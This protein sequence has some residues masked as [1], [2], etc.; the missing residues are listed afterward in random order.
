MW[1]AVR[2][3]FVKI[4]CFP[5]NFWSGSPINPKFM[6]FIF[7]PEKQFWSWETSEIE[8]EGR[9]D[10]VVDWSWAR[11]PGASLETKTQLRRK[12][13]NL[14]L[15]RAA[16]VNLLLGNH[17]TCYATTWSEPH[18]IKLCNKHNHCAQDDDQQRPGGTH[19]SGH[20]Y[21]WPGGAGDAV[22]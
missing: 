14:W 10:K 15:R 18:H 11:R 20:E 12:S 7:V 22:L 8:E 3:G 17:L 5:L 13:C 6:N 1:G 4:N 16:A 9:P 2:W 21:T 19:V